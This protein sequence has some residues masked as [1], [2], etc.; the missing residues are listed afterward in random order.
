MKKENQKGPETIRNAVKG[1]SPEDRV[2]PT[3]YCCNLDALHFGIK[4]SP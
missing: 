3:D 1:S 4:K 2:D